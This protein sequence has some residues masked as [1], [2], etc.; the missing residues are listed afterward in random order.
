VRRTGLGPRV[1]SVVADPAINPA[2]NQPVTVSATITGQTTAVLRYRIDFDAE[3]TVTMTPTATP[4]T[5]TATIP[6]AAAGH[7]IRYRVEATN[8][9]ATTRFPRL[10]DTIN[11]RGLAVPSG[12]TSPIPQW[13]WFISP[14]DYTAMVNNPSQEIVRYGAIAYDGRVY[15][16][17]EMEI[18]GHASQM[19]PKVSWK[20]KTPS[21][22]D[23][24]MPG[25]FVEPVDE[26]DMQADWSDRSHG[27]AILSWD[28]YKRA[29]FEDHTM[30]PVRTQRNGAFQGLYNLQETYDGTWREREG[31]DDNQFFEAE[32]SAFSTRPVNVQFSKKAPD[33][34]DFA[35]MAAFVNGVRLTGTAQR[36]YLLGNADIPQ[37][38]NY[39]AVTAIVEHHD[40]SSKN[41]YMSQDPVTGRWSIIPWDLDHTLGNG[42]CNVNSN[43]VT[44][45][46]AGDNT[47]ALMRA[48]LAQPQ[49]R[50]MYF[51]RLRTLVNDLLAPGRMEA[52][53]DARL[54]PAQPVATLDYSAWPYPGSPVSYATF[55]Q[56]LF[57]EIAA[58]R[59]VFA[60]DARVPGNQSAS[61]D[62]VINEIQHS[63][64]A[65]NTAEF[66]ELY[67]PGSVAIDLSGWKLAGGIDLIVQ[68]GTVIL[69]GSTMTFASNDPGF[70]AAYSPTVFV[71]DRYT[72]DL[73]ASEALTLT[74][75]D[76]SLADTLTYGGE[77]WPVPTSGQ[78]LELTNP[79]ADNNDGAS[80]ALSTG[81]GSPGATNGGITVTAPGAPTIG[82]ATAGNASATVTWTAPASDG[83]APITGYQVKVLDAGGTQVGALRVAGAAATSLLVTGLT[84]GSSYT[85]QVAA[86]NS[87]GTGGFSA[88]STAVT[89]AAGVTAP[90]APAIGAPTAGNG[91][92]TVRWTAP[93]SDGGSAITGYQVRVVNSTG[94]QVGA[95][96]PA[97]ATVTSLLVTGLT[98]GS[99]YRFQVAAT[100]SAGPGA[101][102]ALSAEVTPTAGTATVPGSPVIGIPLQGAI[103]GTLTATARWSAP[104]ST[105]GSAIT[106]Y[107]A[108]ALRMSSAAADATVL[109]RT[110]SK[111][112]GPAV[113]QREFTLP[114][115][116]YRFEVVAINAV[117]TS[118]PSARSAN[119]VPR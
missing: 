45:A 80:W 35:P 43:F 38:I 42:C 26:I 91:A 18:K 31:Y 57:T 70:R 98:N 10:D 117:G 113:K 76:G 60:N 75:P 104:A 9:T 107:Q 50:E 77:G 73:A 47:S 2:A 87:T 4:D 3:Q 92:A 69:P 99:A 78:S 5:Y 112:L 106:G 79:A 16:N 66:V 94:T 71:G 23:F 86:T 55:R 68:P 95:L 1:T 51:R 83:G 32:T 114:A 74:R 111:T 49:W 44:P 39:A 27:R 93:A 53:Y 85:F 15:D 101:Y 96:R 58:R 17:V 89:P 97:G 61:P 84:N 115:G 103:G 67:N 28:A 119:V 54:G 14:T 118:P 30:F 34:T 8:G 19:D 110:T 64:T 88:S 108:T 105:G 72:G 13:E 63:P 7:L 36:D 22:Y 20:F 59:T 81:P 21:G 90:G 109:S 62:I 12:V 46:E 56:R 52:L 82:T 40:S 24:D 6:G 116:N 100:N 37:M 102:S 11:Y 65:G 29:G 41:F 33:E 48:I 25:L